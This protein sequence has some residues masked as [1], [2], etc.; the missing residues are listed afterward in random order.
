[1]VH[2]H[3]GLTEKWTKSI[4]EWTHDIIQ[5]NRE[6]I[7]KVVWWHKKSCKTGNEDPDAKLIAD[8]ASGAMAIDNIKI[9]IFTWFFDTLYN[10][11]Y[12][13]KLYHT[14]RL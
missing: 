13:V 2:L 4:T 6:E 12:N 11:Y 10:L 14:E 5:K 9:D 1:M 7:K 8:G 3:R